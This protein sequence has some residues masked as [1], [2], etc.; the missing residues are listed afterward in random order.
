MLR[1][2]RLITAILFLGVFPAHGQGVLPNSFAGW[3]ASGKGGLSPAQTNTPENHVAATVAKEYDFV[4]GERISYA[5]GA[6]TLDVT[7]YS[8]K[9][10]SGAY[11]EYSFLRSLDMPRAD[12]AEHSSMS[13]DRALVLVGNVVLDI[14]GTNLP[15]LEPQLKSLVAEV[16]KL[17]QTGPLP[18]IGG[19]LPADNMVLR[20][21][22]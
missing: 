10:P 22:H 3:N 12:L 6:D 1:Y 18:W 7:A 11:G 5:R 9:D 13:N 4:S 15:K 14:H 17:A 20:S 2:F 8:M 19:R 16:A 21:D